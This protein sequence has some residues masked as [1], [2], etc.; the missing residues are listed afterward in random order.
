[1]NVRQDP[2][3]YKDG[4]SRNGAPL[5]ELLTTPGGEGS[6]SQRT[7]RRVCDDHHDDERL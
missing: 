3:P 7:T 4:S 6:R 2:H 1:V 5:V